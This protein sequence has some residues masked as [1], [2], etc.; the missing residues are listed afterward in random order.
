[1]NSDYTKKLLKKRNVFNI[2]QLGVMFV[3]AVVYIILACK[4]KT[5]ETDLK[6]KIGTIAYSMGITLV[7]LTALLCIVGHKIRTT[8]WMVNTVLGAYLMGTTGMYIT[9][10]IWLFDE[11]V[12]YNLYTMYKDK[13]KI[14]KEIDKR[15]E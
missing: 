2:L 8:I 12:L 1:M 13:A 5:S 9:F 15:S 7:I 10:G 6:S 4:G 11:Y 14:N 3:V